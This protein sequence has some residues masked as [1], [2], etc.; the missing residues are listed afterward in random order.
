MASVVSK[1]SYEREALTY[2]VGVVAQVHASRHVVDTAGGAGRALF[3]VRARGESGVSGCPVGGS[4]GAG[5]EECTAG[6]THPDGIAVDGGRGR[7][8]D[9]AWEA[10]EAYEAMGPKQ[11]EAF[12][13][14]VGEMLNTFRGELKESQTV[15][16]RRRAEKTVSESH[17]DVKKMVV[18]RLEV[19]GLWCRWGGIYTVVVPPGNYG[20]VGT[21]TRLRRSEWEYEWNGIATN[22][23]RRYRRRY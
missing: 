10:L 11:G 19:G 9:C 1:A 16:G 6:I 2:A 14:G 18:W 5:G 3:E 7:E 22:S 13:V 8:C 17:C 21:S 15:I 12:G 20:R 4:G 23:R